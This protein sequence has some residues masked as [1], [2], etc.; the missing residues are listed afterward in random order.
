MRELIF[1][2]ATRPALLFGVPL[3]AA[4]PVAGLG[5]LLSVYGFVFFR[6]PSVALLVLTVAGAVW[7]WMLQITRRDD[8]RLRQVLL[9]LRLRHSPGSTGLW[10]CNSY[11]PGT[12]RGMK[13]RPE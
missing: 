13:E 1:K 11:G 7:I 3:Q 10:G 12:L 5:I 8:Q 2:G 4:V 9:R 6:A